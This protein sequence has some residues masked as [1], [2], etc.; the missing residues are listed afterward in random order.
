MLF[1]SHLDKTN[2]KLAKQLVNE[3]PKTK[4]SSINTSK[5]H[6]TMSEKI[7]SMN[8]WKVAGALQSPNGIR[9]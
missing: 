7:L 1:S 5:K 8:L 2:F 4:K 3:D 6:S 9:L